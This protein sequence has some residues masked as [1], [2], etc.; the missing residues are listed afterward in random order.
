MGGYL[1]DP[2]YIFGVEVVSEAFSET[3]IFRER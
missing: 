3:D 1:R 2:R